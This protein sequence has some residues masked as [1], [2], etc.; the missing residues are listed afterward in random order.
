MCDTDNVCQASNSLSYIQAQWPRPYTI[1][2]TPL[3]SSGAHLTFRKCGGQL[4]RGQEIFELSELSFHYFMRA[5]Y[6]QDRWI[7]DLLSR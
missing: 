2:D 3:W 4:K 1:V 5:A 7:A 6:K